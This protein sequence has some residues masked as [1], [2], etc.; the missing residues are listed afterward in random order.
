MN[1]IEWVLFVL[2]IVAGITGYL[3]LDW[4]G[5]TSHRT[6]H[7]LLYVTMASWIS[8][9]GTIGMILLRVGR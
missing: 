3:M 6:N 2:M 9:V 7:L 8:I 5:R 4:M 1:T